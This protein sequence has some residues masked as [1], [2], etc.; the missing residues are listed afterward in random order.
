MLENEMERVSPPAL[1]TAAQVA[2]LSRLS[3]CP[4]ILTQRTL[5]EYVGLG[6]STI[7]EHIAKGTFPPPMRL[8]QN[9]IG[10]ERVEVD[11]WIDA[12]ASERP[13][14]GWLVDQK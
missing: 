1:T 7:W 5:P 14:R 4:R 9:R 6:R 2:L 8:S 13:M 12:R 10:W 11:R 3:L